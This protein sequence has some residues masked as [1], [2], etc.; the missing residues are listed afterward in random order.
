ME[1]RLS[2]IAGRESRAIPRPNITN[3]SYVRAYSPF[4]LVLLNGPADIRR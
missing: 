2:G 3:T 4:L 1:A